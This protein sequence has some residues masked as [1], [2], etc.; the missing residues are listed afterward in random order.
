[1]KETTRRNNAW[2]KEDIRELL[3]FINIR[4]EQGVILDNI[5]EQYRE[6]HPE[7]TNLSSH[8]IK[9]VYYRYKNIIDK[10]DNIEH[11][12]YADWTDEEI[13]VLKTAIQEKDPQKSLGSMFVE[14][15]EKIDRSPESIRQQYYKIVRK[16]QRKKAEM[17][18]V[19]DSKE[20]YDFLQSFNTMVLRELQSKIEM[21]VF[22]KKKTEQFDII[23]T[24]IVITSLNIDDAESVYNYFDQM[25][26]NELNT[27]ITEIEIILLDRQEKIDRMNPNKEKAKQKRNY[28]TK[29]VYDLFSNLSANELEKI[30]VIIE[31]MKNNK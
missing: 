13:A 14:L 1:M 18:K 17:P 28:T 26:I 30:S 21:I 22:S 27:I 8:N 19:F 3:E 10:N 24:E 9:A 12:S 5:C 15:S 25:N 20:M 2:E 7:R 16:V 29:E 6:A 11:T 23:P 4:K 31:I